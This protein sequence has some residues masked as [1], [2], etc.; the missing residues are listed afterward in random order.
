MHSKFPYFNDFTDC[1]CTCTRLT[2]CPICVKFGNDINVGARVVDIL[3]VNIAELVEVLAVQPLFSFIVQPLQ[4]L[5]NPYTTRSYI[6]EIEELKE[7]SARFEEEKKKLKMKLEE[8]YRKYEVMQNENIQGIKSFEK[9]NKKAKVKEEC[10][11]KTKI[12]KWRQ[13]TKY[14]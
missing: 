14:A 6:E 5:V 7:A 10:K 9:A 2:K 13:T 8:S 12:I 11:L 3:G 1:N 4:P